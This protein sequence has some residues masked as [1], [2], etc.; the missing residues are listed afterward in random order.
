MLCFGLRGVEITLQLKAYA[1]GELIMCSFSDYRP[2]DET[3]FAKTETKRNP[4]KHLSSY[5]S[6]I[7]N[8]EIKM[9]SARGCEITVGSN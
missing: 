2:Q 8:L 1:A 7:F 4:N 6:R 3:V 5:G 9:N